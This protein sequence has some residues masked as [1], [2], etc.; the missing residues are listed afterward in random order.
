MY[1]IQKDVTLNNTACGRGG[2]MQA[3]VNCCLFLKGLQICCLCTGHAIKVYKV[4]GF[5]NTEI[6]VSN[7]IRDNRDLRWPS[8]IFIEI[9]LFVVYIVNHFT[10]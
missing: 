9:H 10:S 7:P 8:L 4:F 1:K 5:I 2:Y 6:A 3:E